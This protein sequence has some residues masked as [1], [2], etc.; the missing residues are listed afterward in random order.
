MSA[1]GSDRIYWAPPEV[2]GTVVRMAKNGLA[3]LHACS[4]AVIVAPTRRD[5][6]DPMA[7]GVCRYCGERLPVSPSTGDL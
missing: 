7:L 4:S 6:L 1:Q 2:H 3:L 5:Q